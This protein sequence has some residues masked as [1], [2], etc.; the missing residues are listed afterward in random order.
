V[1]TLPIAGAVFAAAALSDSPAAR[2][3]SRAAS[4]WTAAL[5]LAGT[6]FHLYGLHRRYG[7][8]D[9]RA[10]FNWLNGPPAPAPLQ[11]LGLGLAGL[12][13][14]RAGAAR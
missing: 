1:V 14:E 8:D 7:G 12:A 4:G 2:T 13:A 3:A 5:G 9:R 11:I 6:G 10:L